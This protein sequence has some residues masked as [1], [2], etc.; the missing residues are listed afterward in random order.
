MVKL[1]ASRA[2]RDHTM[3]QK[4]KFYGRAIRQDDLWI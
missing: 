3:E 1:E 2:L 4:R